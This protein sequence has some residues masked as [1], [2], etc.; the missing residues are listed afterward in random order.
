MPQSYAMP[1]DDETEA[2]QIHPL[3]PGWVENLRQPWLEYVDCPDCGR[4]L[5]RNWDDGEYFCAPC[6]LVL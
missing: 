3:P 2:F 1:L 4:E 6:G 5:V